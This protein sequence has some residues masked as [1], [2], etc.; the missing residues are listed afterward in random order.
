MVSYD[1][2][3]LPLQFFDLPDSEVLLPPEQWFAHV[4]ASRSQHHTWHTQSCACLRII[5]I[6]I[7]ICVKPERGPQTKIL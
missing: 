3:V 5:C 4:P 2:V 7:Y 1:M 6:Y